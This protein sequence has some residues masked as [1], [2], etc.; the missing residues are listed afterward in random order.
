MYLLA[1]GIGLG[2]RCYSVII[3][4]TE[5]K[6]GKDRFR[7][8]PEI[9]ARARMLNMRARTLTQ[10]IRKKM[11]S[12]IFVAI[13]LASQSLLPTTLSQQAIPT[14][15][16]QQAI[17]T[18]LPQQAIPTTLPQQAIPTTLPQRAIPTTLPQQAES[19]T[20]NPDLDLQCAVKLADLRI[21]CI[22]SIVSQSVKS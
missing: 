15:F 20:T 21:D 2:E 11:K 6:T 19:G 10:L 9:R 16:P 1:G 17:P 4:P 22:T 7:G 13:L 8:N 12:N 18:T 14:T 5:G 3:I